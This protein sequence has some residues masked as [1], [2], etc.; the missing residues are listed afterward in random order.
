MGNVGFKL[1]FFGPFSG[2]V[3][4]CWRQDGEQERQDGDQERQNEPRWA[5]LSRKSERSVRDMRAAAATWA[6]VVDP[7]GA[8]KESLEFDIGTI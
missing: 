2:D 6:C 5:N 7:V 8:F 1:G 3:G 4:A